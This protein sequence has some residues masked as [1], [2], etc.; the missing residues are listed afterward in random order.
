MP[1]VEVTAIGPERFRVRV[2]D[3]DTSTEHEVVAST[4]Y[5]SGV[6]LGGAD[7]AA[8]VRKSFS[9]LLEREPNTSILRRFSLADIARYFPDYPDELR[10]R[11][12]G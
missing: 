6:G 10:R 7:P 8:V 1:D 11:L 5:L 3:G 2:R 9:F 12:S 4:D